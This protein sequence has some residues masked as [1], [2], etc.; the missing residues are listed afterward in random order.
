MQVNAARMREHWEEY[1]TF[2]KEGQREQDALITLYEAE[3]DELSAQLSRELLLTSKDQ[4]E[5]ENKSDENN[6]VAMQLGVRLKRI[7]NDKKGLCVR[8]IGTP[9]FKMAFGRLGLDG[10]V[11]EH[12]FEERQVDG[13]QSNLNF[14]LKGWVSSFSFVLYSGSDLRHISDQ[15]VKDAPNFVRGFGPNDAIRRLLHL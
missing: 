5:V 1:D 4:I 13:K 8:R 15:K 11:F 3:V 6:R 2:M 9:T 14:D 7:L 10:E 12:F